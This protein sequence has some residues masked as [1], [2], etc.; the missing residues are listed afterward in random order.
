M[1]RRDELSPALLPRSRD[2][3]P[4][5]APCCKLLHKASVAQTCAGAGWDM[6][7]QVELVLVSS[8]ALRGPHFRPQVRMNSLQFHAHRMSCE[9]RHSITEVHHWLLPTAEGRVVQEGNSQHCAQIPIDDTQV[10]YSSPS[11]PCP[12]SPG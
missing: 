12:R 2:I 11:R 8:A 3:R 10:L 5:G 1:A 7:G 9:R 6:G 4:K